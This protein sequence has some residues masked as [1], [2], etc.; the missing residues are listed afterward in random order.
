MGKLSAFQ[1]F[2]NIWGESEENTRFQKPNALPLPITIQKL[3]GLDSLKVVYFK[4]AL[5]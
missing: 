5:I 2:T 4:E 3:D 1:E